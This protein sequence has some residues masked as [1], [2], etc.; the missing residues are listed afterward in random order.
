[1]LS[2][3]KNDAL[4]VGT[5]GVTA[6]A[7]NIVYQ[8][9]GAI[10]NHLLDPAVKFT[11]GLL[12]KDTVEKA[13][14]GTAKKAAKAGKKAAK[15]GKKA[16]K[17]IL[18][19]TKEKIGKIASAAVNKET[20][21]KAGRKVAEFSNKVASATKDNTVKFIQK[22]SFTKAAKVAGVTAAVVAAGLVVKKVFDKIDEA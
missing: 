3:E 21:K 20:Y 6:G 7:A 16:A 1:M 13:A 8:N 4:T 22:T 15:A 9:K 19:N 17:G 12:K 2:I 14:N 11:K 10:K 5:V 18:K